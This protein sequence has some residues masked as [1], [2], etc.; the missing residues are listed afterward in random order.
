MP[1]ETIS[2]EASSAETIST[3]AN[4]KKHPNVEAISDV[5]DDEAI[6]YDGFEEALIGVATQFGRPTVA[7]YSLP[8]CLQV[9]QERDG[10][11][12]EDA[13]E[14]LMFNVVGGYLGEYTPV[15]FTSTQEAF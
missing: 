14:F 12:E 8:K 9:L 1:T 10:M 7:A 2:T 4:I 11:S 5:L 13:D 6:L 3:E 15:F